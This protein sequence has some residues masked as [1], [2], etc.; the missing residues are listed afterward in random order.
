MPDL[1]GSIVNIQIVSIAASGPCTFIC[2]SC[3]RRI[4][5]RY[6][7][8]YADLDGPPWT[9]MCPQCAGVVGPLPDGVCQHG[10]NAHERGCRKC[11]HG[12]E[13]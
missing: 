10:V 4:D 5:Q 3:E 12:E 7:D 11:D 13:L 1:R 2:R 6:Q 8:V 9:Y